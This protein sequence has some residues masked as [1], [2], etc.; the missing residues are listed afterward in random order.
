MI[1]GVIGIFL[2][3]YL[4]VVLVGYYQKFH[5][6][7]NQQ[8][9][10]FIF[11][12]T[13]AILVTLVKEY[14]LLPK[15]VGITLLT[16]MLGWLLYHWLKRP[17][18]PFLEQVKGWK[19]GVAATLLLL[20]LVISARGSLIG[21]PAQW[22]DA[23]VTDDYFLNLSTV[24]PEMALYYALGVYQEMNSSKGLNNF[25]PDGDIRKAVKE[26][27][28]T[29]RDFPDL[30][31]YIEHVAKGNINGK[32]SHI[33][34]IVM[35]S[36]HSW[37]MLPAY[38]ELGLANGLKRI[39]SRGIWVKRFLP[40]S[41]STMRSLSAIFTGL[42]NAGLLLNYEAGTNHPLPTSLTTLFEDL[43]YETN[44]FYGGYLSWQ[45]L[46]RFAI[47]QGFDHIYGAGHFPRGQHSNEWGVD[48]ETLFKFIEDKVS[49]DSPHSV[50]LIMTTT[51]HP[52]FD[53]DVDDKGF[54]LKKIPQHFL[55]HLPEKFDPE[56]Y[57]QELGH[58]WY[59]D[60][61]LESFVL[62]MHKRFPNALFAITGDHYGGNHISDQASLFERRSVP[63]VLFGPNILKNK[64]LPE[65]QVGTHLDMLTTLV[66]LSATEGHKYSSLGR[67]L[68][69]PPKSLNTI[70]ANSASA[71]TADT[72]YFIQ[73]Q[74]WKPANMG[75]D[76][77][78]RM[79][80]YHHLLQGLSWWMVR[81]GMVLESPTTPSKQY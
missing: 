43:G 36:Y 62:K 72:L 35:E 12:D 66:E 50:S 20:L 34:I 23:A 30:S 19:K 73:R 67:D 32:P 2:L 70:T 26:Y 29:D 46:E 49:S 57:R 5:D 22:K 45:K 21:R 11:D 48:D 42:S 68:L 51:N 78:K 81:Y 59:A 55:Q 77:L 52:P 60:R 63:L 17:I 14:N 37:P 74:Q 40:A 44:L 16:G 80:H 39:A 1:W 8:L 9:F 71:M 58:F 31:G 3:V 10:D 54:P 27:T 7:F 41:V 64:T 53:L 61:L 18:L 33:F 4:Q 79:K 69:Q 75:K 65:H 28:G 76:E 56:Q 38:A 15:L 13:G 47:N 24:N 25:L 6:T